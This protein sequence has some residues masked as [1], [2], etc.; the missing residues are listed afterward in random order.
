MN[1]KIKQ[2]MAIIGLIVIVG[3]FVVT[4]VLALSKNPNTR[5]WF[6]ASIIVLVVVPVMMYVCSW[7]YKLIKKQKDEK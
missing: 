1:K 5:G 3:M 2:V 4:I 7:L 6:M